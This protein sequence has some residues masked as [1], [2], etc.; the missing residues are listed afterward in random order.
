MGFKHSLASL[1]VVALYLGTLRLGIQN[2]FMIFIAGKLE[3]LIQAQVPPTN[4]VGR[5]F[6][7][8]M[9]RTGEFGETK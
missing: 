4:F 7:F 1:L 3:H 8:G 5:M 2:N 6:S 9:V